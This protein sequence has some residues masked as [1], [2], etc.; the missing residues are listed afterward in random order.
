MIIASIFGLLWYLSQGQK[1]SVVSVPASVRNKTRS[2]LDFE[3]TPETI[4]PPQS[5]VGVEPSQFETSKT[6]G[7]RRIM[8]EK[9]L[10]Y[11]VETKL[12][13]R[14]A[15]FRKLKQQIDRINLLRDAPQSTVEQ[16]EEERFR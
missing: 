6:I 7:R 4:K 9:G 3:A 10:A 5:V 2:E 1:M 14:N 12:A 11:Q 15:T 8:N 16:L 13:N